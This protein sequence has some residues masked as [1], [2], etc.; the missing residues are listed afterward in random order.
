MDLKHY[1]CIAGLFDYPHSDFMQAVTQTGEFLEKRYPAAGSHMQAF[2]HFVAGQNLP[3]LEEIFMRSFDIQA[4]TTLDAGYVL[5]GDDYK[6][7]ELLSQLN[8]EHQ[9]AGNSCG[10]ELADHLPN[11]LRLLSKLE[12]KELVDDLI[13]II[14]IPALRKMLVE[15]EPE[16][17]KTKN[18]LYQKHYKTLISVPAQQSHMYRHALAA[19]LAVIEQDFAIGEEVKSEQ[20][21]NDFLHSV[22][23]EISIEKV[24]NE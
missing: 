7:G 3:A 18:E 4:A 17:I 23:A 19:V 6:R 9:K 1:A 2:A 15:F 10:L 21:E 24:E 12:D 14:I 13:Q 8:R 11:L 20:L 16:R 22:T 5:F